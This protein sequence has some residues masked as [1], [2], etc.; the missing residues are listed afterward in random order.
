ML[1]SESEAAETHWDDEMQ[2]VENGDSR[3]TDHVPLLHHGI[4][5][6]DFGAA[7][8]LGTPS[9]SKYAYTTI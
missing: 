3:L 1:T 5:P 2:A 4:L 8:D 9:I 7:K 6:L